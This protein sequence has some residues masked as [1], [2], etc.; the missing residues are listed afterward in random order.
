MPIPVWCLI[1]GG[2][3][4]L[5]ALLLISKI[6]LSL[7]YENEFSVYLKFLFLKFKLYPEKEKKSYKK[8]KNKDKNASKPVK[9]EEKKAI[10]MTPNAIVKLV[11]A[12]KDIALDLISSFFGR[13]HIKFF[14][15]RAEIGCEDAAKTAVAY[16]V[17]VQGVAYTLEFLDTISNVDKSRSSDVDIRSNFIS[18]KSWVELNCMLYLRVFQLFPLG[19]KGLKA[20][21]RFQSFK[22][23]LLE[24]ENNGTIE[25][26]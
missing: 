5:V 15:V 26:K 22:E 7:I 4:L 17:V 13:L 14:K 1:L 3:L 21:F 2:A 19:I 11:Q 6:K 10:K 25:T 16:G 24:V 8:A 20:F 23:K 9:Q 18:Q 12:M